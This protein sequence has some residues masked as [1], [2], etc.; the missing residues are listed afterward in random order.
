MKKTETAEE[1]LARLAEDASEGKI[2]A[3]RFETLVR[4]VAA[5]PSEAAKASEEEPTE[6]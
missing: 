6:A 5:T 3:K 4:R 2:A 1:T